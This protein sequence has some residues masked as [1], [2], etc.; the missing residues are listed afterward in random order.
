VVVVGGRAGGLALAAE[1]AVV[2]ELLGFPHSFELAITR[3]S[4]RAIADAGRANL[5][6]S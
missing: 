5:L 1:V 2:E 6:I 4:P 3:R